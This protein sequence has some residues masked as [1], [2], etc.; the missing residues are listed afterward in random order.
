MASLKQDFAP[1]SSP[2]H[3]AKSCQN[4][5]NLKLSLKSSPWDRWSTRRALSR[6]AGGP[7]RPRTGTW[8]Q[9]I[10]IYSFKCKELLK[11]LQAPNWSLRVLTTCSCSLVSVQQELVRVFCYSNKKSTRLHSVTFPFL[12]DFKLNLHGVNGKKLYDICLS[13]SWQ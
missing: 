9:V 7:A 2:Q 8:P 6:A 11:T 12:A 1:S 4:S 3:Q 5:R 10:I 13:N